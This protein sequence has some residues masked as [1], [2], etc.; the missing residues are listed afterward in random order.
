MR[1]AVFPNPYVGGN[2][3]LCV[4]S[5]GQDDIEVAAQKTLGDND[6][7]YMIVEEGQI[8]NGGPL[9]NAMTV[10][11]SGS[12]PVFGFDV[13]EAKVL[14]TNINIGYWQLQSNEALAELNMSDYQLLV[15]LS[16]P[17]SQR[18]DEQQAAVDA[19]N[20]INTLQM[21]TQ[22]QINAA[23]TGEELLTILSQLG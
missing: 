19:I 16:T 9:V 2:D 3:V 5:P 7:P 21:Q 15:A 23:T 6:I 14:S 13:P 8:P 22:D 17:E 1:V 11:V 20:E 12:E 18:T 4:L 10:D